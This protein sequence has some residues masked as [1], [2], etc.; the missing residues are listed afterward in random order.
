MKRFCV[1]ILNDISPDHQDELN[2]VLNNLP[3]TAEIISITHSA[4]DDFSTLIVYSIYD[5]LESKVH[6]PY[7]QNPVEEPTKSL[8]KSDA[9]LLMDY[10]K[11]LQKMIDIFGNESRRKKW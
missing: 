6:T 7:V 3:E 5:E 4:S 2:K 1:L 9:D 10:D 11:Q 8:V